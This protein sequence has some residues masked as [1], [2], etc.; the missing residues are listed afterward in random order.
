MVPWV[1]L[2]TEYSVNLPTKIITIKGYS[3]RVSEN[4]CFDGFIFTKLLKDII[5]I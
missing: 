5:E 4:E 1:D 3:K 2:F